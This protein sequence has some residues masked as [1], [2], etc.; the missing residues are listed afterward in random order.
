MITFKTDFLPNPVS[1]DKPE[2]RNGEPEYCGF[3]V[4][5]LN[6]NMDYT[7]INLKLTKLSR[8]CAMANRAL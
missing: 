1:L 5:E 8:L 6:E 3:K 2:R 4:A 7:Y